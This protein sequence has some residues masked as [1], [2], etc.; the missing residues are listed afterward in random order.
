M[1]ITT[2]SQLLSP[3]DPHIKDSQP[4]VLET[5]ELKTENNRPVLTEFAYTKD[6]KAGL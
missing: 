4:V 6:T 2:L 5:K 1:E 3:E